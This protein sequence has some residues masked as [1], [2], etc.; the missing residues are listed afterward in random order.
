MKRRIVRAVAMTSQTSALAPV[1]ASPQRRGSFRSYSCSPQ[2]N[3][4]AVTFRG[5]RRG[6]REGP[7][8]PRL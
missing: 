3:W 1:I 8:E 6:E 5:E 4:D 2:A 7:C